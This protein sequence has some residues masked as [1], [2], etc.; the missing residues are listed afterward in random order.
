MGV[1]YTSGG[2]TLARREAA[3]AYL[4]LTPA[5]LL[6]VSLVLFPILWNVALSLQEIRLIELRRVNF[7][8]IEATL[9]NFRRVIGAR[10]FW[11]LVRT[12]FAYAFF[13][14][15]LALL[16]GLWAAMVVRRTF[17]GRTLV[18]GL[19]LVPYVIPIVASAFVWRVMLSP[20]LGI[21]NAWTTRYLGMPYVDVLNQRSM[22]LSLLDVT[23]SVPVALT[24]VILFEGWR[25]FPF[26]FLFILARLQAIP[27]D[28]EEAAH[29]D[30][31]TPWQTFRYVILPQL[32]SV[33]AVLFL[34]RFIWVFNKFDD[35]FLLTGGGAGTEVVSVQIY[36]W[37]VGRSDIGAAA[38]LSLVLAGIL[39]V[40]LFFYFRYVYTEEEL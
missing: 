21:V 5:T 7:L 26:A 36:E 13:G 34:L 30:G 27:E 20:Q 25:Y 15:S 35:V 2:P 33:F 40:L 38:A 24:F 23:I 1:V 14:T 29:V 12:T 31:A 22:E 18:R 4:F 28:L 6:V 8:E 11:G 39:A 17:P 16:L 9:A 10:G 32:R 3:T 37:L 19:I